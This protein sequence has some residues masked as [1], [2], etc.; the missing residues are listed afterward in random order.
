MEAWLEGTTWGAV[1]AFFLRAFS[2]LVTQG[3]PRALPRLKSSQS[4]RQIFRV[5]A[6]RFVFVCRF[7]NPEKKNTELHFAGSKLRV[8]WPLSSYLAGHNVNVSEFDGQRLSDS[9]LGPQMFGPSS[10]KYGERVAF[11]GV[12]VLRASQITFKVPRRFRKSSQ[13]P[14][15]KLCSSYSGLGASMLVSAGPAKVAVSLETYLEIATFDLGKSSDPC[16]K[17]LLEIC[18]RLPPIR[19]SLWFPCKGKDNDEKGYPSNRRPMLLEKKVWF[20]FNPGAGVQHFEG[21]EQTT[22]GVCWPT[23]SK[24]KMVGFLVAL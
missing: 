21:F 3:R 11:K 5:S 9:E 15:E 8:A 10:Q 2:G 17:V 23:G 12:N 18:V 13:H 22:F 4:A 19:F 6:P 20:A 14:F 7:W 16:L 24:Q 1:L